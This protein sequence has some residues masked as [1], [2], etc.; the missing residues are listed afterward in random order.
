MDRNA[1]DGYSVNLFLDEDGD[2]LAHFLEMPGISA[3]GD[4]PEAALAELEKAWRL[5]KRSYEENSESIPVAPSCREYSGQFNVRIKQ[6]G[7]RL[8]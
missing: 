6:A 2:W 7:I 1:F 8:T 3:F 5:A 4:T